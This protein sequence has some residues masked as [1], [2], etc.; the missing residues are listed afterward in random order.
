[1]DPP[2]LPKLARNDPDLARLFSPVPHGTSYGTRQRKPWFLQL[3][4][5]EADALAGRPAAG[6]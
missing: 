6:P 5:A 2:R 1:V 4:G 3:G